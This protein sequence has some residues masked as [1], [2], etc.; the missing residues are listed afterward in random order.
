MFS[1]LCLIMLYVYCLNMYV[2]FYYAL[3]SHMYT[4]LFMMHPSF[5]LFPSYSSHPHR[6]HPLP[7]TPIPQHITFFLFSFFEAITVIQYA[8][9]ELQHSTM[10]LPKYFS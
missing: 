1:L 10:E 9:G 4:L 8:I 6:T 5:P 7:L 2:I 3:L